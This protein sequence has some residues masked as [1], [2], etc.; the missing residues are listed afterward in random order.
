MQYR[1]VREVTEY[2]TVLPYTESRSMTHVHV[3][4]QAGKATQAEA[5]GAS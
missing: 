1:G 3:S 5:A 2:R 4:T